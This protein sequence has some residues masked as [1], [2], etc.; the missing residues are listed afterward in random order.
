MYVLQLIVNA[1]SVSSA[2]DTV[3]IN[4]QNQAPIARPDGDKSRGNR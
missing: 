3:L 1:G 4:T 2:P